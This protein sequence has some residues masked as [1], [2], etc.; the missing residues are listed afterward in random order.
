M[1]VHGIERLRLI[2]ICIVMNITPYQMYV[3]HALGAQHRSSH[4]FNVLVMSQ[5]QEELQY[6]LTVLEETIPNVTE[7]FLCA[8]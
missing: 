8:G 3:L 1:K 2:I 6:S 7:Q 5:R 4:V